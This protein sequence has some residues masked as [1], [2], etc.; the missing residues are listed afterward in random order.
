MIWISTYVGRALSPRLVLG[1][2]PT[3]FS[4]RDNLGVTYVQHTRPAYDVWVDLN[5]FQSEG[6]LGGRRPK[7]FGIPPQFAS[8]TGL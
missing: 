5:F 2:V 1:S 3:Q 6:A 4:A 8:P 7:G